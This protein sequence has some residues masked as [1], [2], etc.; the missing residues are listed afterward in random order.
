[1]LNLPEEILTG[2]GPEEIF[3]TD[4]KA[5]AFPRSRPSDAPITD[6]TPGIFRQEEIE[7][8][9]DCYYFESDHLA[10]KGNQD[11]LKMLETV[12]T[13]Q[14]QRTQAINDLETL[15]QA[16]K[17]AMEMDAHL[18][19]TKLKNGELPEYPGPQK[20]IDIPEIDWSKY[21]IFK[22][23][24]ILRPQTRTS[25]EPLIKR[26]KVEERM[27]NTAAVK[28]KA[29]DDSKPET[30]GQKWSC[31]EQQKLEE[32]LRI[33]PSEENEMNR[34]RKIAE[35]LGNVYLLYIIYLYI[36]IKPILYI[37]FYGT[38]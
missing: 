14:A 27:N 6:P 22:P 4:Y 33:Y 12:I 3:R 7:D 28:S 24:Q 9:K 1:M 10:L 34:F 23:D 30:F 29:Q 17:N 11:Y 19:V 38:S 36:L 26:T 16:K 5:A 2:C 32:L 25:S 8:P 21:H 15:L 37:F 31:E 35:A 13:L 18:Y 20:I